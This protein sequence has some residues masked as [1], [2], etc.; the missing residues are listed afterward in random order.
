MT[1]L[2]FP[3]LSRQA[4][5]QVPWS[6]VSNTQVFQSPLSAAVQTVEMPAALLGAVM[7]REQRIDDKGRGGTEGGYSRFSDGYPA[8]Y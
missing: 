7:S 4:P 2:T 1:T 6:L 8:T 5:P 3:T